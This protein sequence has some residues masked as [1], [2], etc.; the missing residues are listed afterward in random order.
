MEAKKMPRALS[1]WLASVLLASSL[2]ACQVNQPELSMEP[3]VVDASNLAASPG[4]AVST[5]TAALPMQL[6]KLPLPLRE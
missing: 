1:I 4:S 2:E 5:N 6:R 3:T